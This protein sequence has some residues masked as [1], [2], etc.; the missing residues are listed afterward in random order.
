[1]TVNSAASN[2]PK[3]VP[4]AHGDPNGSMMRAEVATSNL[5]GSNQGIWSSLT[6]KASSLYNAVTTTVQNAAS[7]IIDPN[8]LA[9]S[10]REHFAP[11]LDAVGSI[12]KI[13]SGTGNPITNMQNL[14]FAAIGASVA[15]LTG[16]ILVGIW[17][18]TGGLIISGL[19]LTILGFGVINAYY[20]PILPAL[21][22]YGAVIGW[23][24]LYIECL[25][26]APIWA[27][28]HIRFDG[29]GMTGS[30]E[31][32]YRIL[33]NMFLRP[34]LITIGF[35]IAMS[36]MEMI[37]RGWNL[38][39]AAA[40]A[41]NFSTD[42]VSGI[43]NHVV[44]YFVYVLTMIP[45]IHRVLRIT[46][47]VP[48]AVAKWIGGGHD[49]F[50]SESGEHLARQSHAGVQVAAGA[51]AGTAAQGANSIIRDKGNGSGK[52]EGRERLETPIITER[53]MNTLPSADNGRAEA[54]ARH[55]TKPSDCE[56]NS[57]QDKFERPEL[58][59]KEPLELPEENL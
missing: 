28:M 43:I 2:L 31:A 42:G 8:I 29:E 41:A 44:L 51:M 16:A 58:G 54:P 25:V 49:A 12:G 20:L 5:S 26:A 1:A 18:T 39:F 48:E 38:T 23:F 3:S 37:V 14:G 7:S 19:S 47:I 35:A 27:L 33:L 4:P 9:N 53:T 36:S 46:T 30:A 56:N 50:G 15:G 32:G 17:S 34:S 52:E 11:L 55:E 6:D 13:A 57:L 40:F 24:I 59:E 45:I 22:Y 10:M 21:T